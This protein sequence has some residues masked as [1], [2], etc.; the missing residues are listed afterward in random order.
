MRPLTCSL[1]RLELVVGDPVG[2]DRAEL[3]A[4]DLAGLL[5]VVLAGADV[6]ADHAAVD[7]LLRVGADRVGEPLLL[8]DLPEEAGGGR[9]AEDGVEDAERVAALVAAIDARAAEADVELLGV[10]LLEGDLGAVD[11][12]APRARSPLTVGRR[13]APRGAC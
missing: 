13:A 4:D 12:W 10:L 2:V 9:A 5:D 3:T 11:L 1:A 7:V 6:E 8:A